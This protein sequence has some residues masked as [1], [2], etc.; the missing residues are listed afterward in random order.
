MKSASIQIQSILYNNEKK[1]L[2]I[3]LENIAN[4][5]R[6]EKNNEILELSITV[7]YGDASPSPLFTTKEVEEICKKFG[8]FLVFNY[9]F[10]DE[11]TGSAKGHNLLAENCT[12]EYMLI[13]NPD[14]ILNPHI[15]SQLLAP[16]SNPTDK[17]GITEARQ[18]PIEHHKVYDEKTGE[19]SWVTTAC[20]LFPHSIFEEV[21]GF[22]SE[23][24]FMYCDDLDF[25]WRVRL[26]GYI[27]IY[28]PGAI[29]FHSKYL[30][31]NGEWQPTDSEIY[32][33]AESSLFMAYKWS[34]MNRLENILNMYDN[35]GDKFCKKAAKMF[36]NR[37]AEGKLP[38]Q[39]DADHK[40]ASFTE[41]GYGKYRFV[42]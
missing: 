25:S 42:F 6:V 3:A 27:C 30:G 33:S 23:S 4:A 8:N 39:L 32:Y 13:Q 16:F 29:V 11:N 31:V 2:I 9:T 24:F 7:S 17:V 22:D 14:V 28:V 26:A 36:R 34:D 38:K 35:S 18:T 1:A 21:G 15:F 5:I 12:S 10:F 20:A 37:Q 19:T 40:V 41:Q